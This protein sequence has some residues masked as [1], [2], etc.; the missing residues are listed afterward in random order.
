MKKRLIAVIVAISLILV[1]LGVFLVVRHVRNNR[2]PELSAIRE[3]VIALIDASHEVNEVFWGEGLATYPRVYKE[4]YARV[5]FYLVKQGDGYVF[6]ATTADDKLYYYTFTDETVGDILAYQYCLKTGDGEYVDVE[7]GGALTIAD[8]IK[9]RYAKKTDAPVEGAEPIFSRNDSYYYALPDYAE[10]EAEF[11]YTESDQE[12]YDYVRND[13]AYL[14]TADI[15]AKAEK[16]YAEEFLSSVY[17]SIFTGITVSESSSGTL[18]ARYIDYKDAEG[19]GYLM[20]SNLWKPAEVGRVYLF[21]TMRM[22]EERRS[23]RTDV[24]IDIDTYVP[25]DEANVTTVTVSLTLQDG[26]WFLNS[27]T[28]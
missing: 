4:Y 7:K 27:A 6:S 10:K 12:Y 17:E 28:Y 2:P 1:S 14:T 25:G 22:S 13:A 11:Y 9:Y 8:K 24:Y 5:P 18:Y 21:D 19:N 15:K 16:V 26:G 3:R 20:K 23:K